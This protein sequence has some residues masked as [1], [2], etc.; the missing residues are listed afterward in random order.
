MQDAVYSAMFG[1][2]TAEHR[3][4]SIANNLANVSTT[5]FKRERLNFQDMVSRPAAMTLDP[6][7]T[8]RLTG[9]AG[10]MGAGP[11]APERVIVSQPRIGQAR[12]DF[13]DGGMRQTGNTLDLAIQGEGFFKV[14]APEGVRY[15]RDGSFRL[16]PEGELVTA[17]GYQVLGEGGPI[18]VPEGRDFL[19]SS[20]GVVTA[21]VDE[22]GRLS[23]VAVENPDQTLEKHGRNLFRA[24]DGVN[25]SES[26]PELSTVAQGFLE[27]ANVEIVEEMVNMIET[28]RAFE[29]YQK[30]MTSSQTMDERL[31]RDVGVVR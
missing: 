18:T 3:M 12:L 5:G 1:A 31:M 28:N 8:V 24:K 21:G 22:V 29:A 23:V 11:A 20:S 26:R 16:S 7:P 10:G 15:T 6:T 25:A 27:A 9:S 2:M 30:M 4:N 17:Q 14:Q 13:S 19:V